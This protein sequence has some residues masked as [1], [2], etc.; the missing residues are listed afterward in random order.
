ML[1][2]PLDALDKRESQEVVCWCS[3]LIP[4]SIH[5]GEVHPGQV[6]AGRNGSEI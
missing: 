3:G 1:E 2:R 4:V 6:I 5:K